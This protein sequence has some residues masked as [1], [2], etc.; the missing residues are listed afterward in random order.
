MPPTASAEVLQLAG[1]RAQAEL[2]VLAKH[3]LASRLCSNTAEHDAVQQG[4]AA[5]AV[6][7]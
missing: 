7:A 2:V 1:V 4:V 3:V 6:V 5:Q